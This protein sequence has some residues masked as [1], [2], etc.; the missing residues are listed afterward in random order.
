MAEKV[1]LTKKLPRGAIPSPRS[2]LRQLCRMFQ[3]RKY[4]SHR[5]S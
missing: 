4:R 1:D 2:D 5:A 3:T